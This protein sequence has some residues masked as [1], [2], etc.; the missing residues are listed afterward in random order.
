MTNERVLID[1]DAGVD[2]ILAIFIATRTEWAIDFAVSFGNI[3]INQ[4]IYN[5]ALFDTVSGFTPERFFVGSS[6]PILGAP[7]FAFDVHG[8]DGLGGNS[9]FLGRAPDQPAT[10]DLF[11]KAKLT[12]YDKIIALGPLTDISI[13]SEGVLNPPPLFVMGGA[14]DTPGNVSAYA[15]F[16]FFA[17]PKAA[18]QV[19]DRYQ[20]NVFVVPLDVCKLVVLG[21]SYLTELCKRNGS[22]T[23]FFLQ[24]IHQHYM[25]FYQLRENID[26]CYPHDALCVGAAI[27]KSMFSWDRG[28]VQIVRDGSE[29]GRSI[30]RRE[31][32]GPHYVAR[33]VNVSGFFALVESAING[34]KERPQHT[35]Y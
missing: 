27:D 9:S 23:T 16:N 7:R 28:S 12:D 34:Y 4:A 33:D 24:L 35:K 17:D 20:G 3:P 19:F 32:T 10:Y 18:S 15:E 1:T 25:D 11:K 22:R 2:D 5:I 21:R 31:R 30:F 6:S 14:F 29:Q 8:V 13:S 26:G